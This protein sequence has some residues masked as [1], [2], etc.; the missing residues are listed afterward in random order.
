M[1]EVFIAAQPPLAIPSAEAKWWFGV[2]L[3]PQGGVGGLPG[4]VVFF[5]VQEPRF[6]LVLDRMAEF[7]F[8]EFRFVQ[9]TCRRPLPDPRFRIINDNRHPDLAN[10]ANYDLATKAGKIFGRLKDMRRA[11]KHAIVRAAIQVWVDRFE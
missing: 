11:N 4:D 1:L 6:R 7:E 9:N 10:F 2:T 8:L 5:C 3:F